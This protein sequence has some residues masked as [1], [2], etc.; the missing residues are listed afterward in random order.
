MQSFTSIP[1]KA[2][3]GMSS[4]NGVAKFSTAG[5]VLEFESKLFGLISNGVKE[6]RLAV[7]EILDIKFKK[8]VFKRGSKIEIRA[9]SLAKLNEMPN[10]E[11][12]VTLKIESGDFEHARD[13]VDMIQKEMNR[14]DDALPPAHTPISVLF[15]ESE[16]E[17]KELN[18][19][20]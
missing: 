15:D 8:G 13:V 14:R 20:R 16:D 2:E 7:S 11:G 19:D 5:I 10:K 3:S 1:F 17:T 6:S 12:R 18:K 9:R 4:V